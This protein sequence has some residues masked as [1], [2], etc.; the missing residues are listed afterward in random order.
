M[1]KKDEELAKWLASENPTVNTNA[2]SQWL[3]SEE[4]DPSIPLPISDEPVLDTPT[5][6]RDLSLRQKGV[7]L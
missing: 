1:S 5:V 7:N 3:G 2:L 4:T 6:E